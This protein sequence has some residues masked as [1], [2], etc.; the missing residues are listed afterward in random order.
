MQYEK[1]LSPDTIKAYRIDLQQFSDFTKGV[2]AVKDM[3]D[4]YI[5]YLN[6]H[7]A[8]RS[9]KCKLASAHAF[10][11]EKKISGESTE[12]PFEKLHIRIHSPKQLPRIIPE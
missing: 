9:V 7:F 11:H 6:Q 12:N 8:P 5:K 3:L 10:Y 4:R 2:W 1:Q